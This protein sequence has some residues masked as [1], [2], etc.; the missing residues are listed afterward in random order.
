MISS[1]AGNGVNITGADA[2]GNTVLNNIIGLTSGGTS[3]LGNA[4]G[5][6]GRHRARAP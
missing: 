2:T 5:R 6:S 1:N 4:P 3:V